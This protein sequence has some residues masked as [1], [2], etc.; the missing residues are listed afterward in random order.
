MCV[1]GWTEKRAKGY[2]EAKMK[3]YNYGVG[4]IGRRG[5]FDLGD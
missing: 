3:L 1:V 4:N 5:R 2:K